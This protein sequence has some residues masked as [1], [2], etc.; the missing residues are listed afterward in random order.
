VPGGPVGRSEQAAGLLDGQVVDGRLAL[1]LGW[2][3]EDVLA[4]GQLRGILRLQ[5]SRER[6]DR[7]EALVAGRQAVV[8]VGLQPVQESGDGGGVDAVEGES[9]WRDGS[10]VA[11][12]DD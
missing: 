10:V 12:E 4:A 1:F 5:P 6:A 9:F 2:D 3:G 11:E 8:P 7:G